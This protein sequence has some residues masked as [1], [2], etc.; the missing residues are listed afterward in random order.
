MTSTVADDLSD[1]RPY[2]FLLSSPNHA[3]IHRRQSGE[4]GL[5]SPTTGE[6]RDHLLS[7][8]SMLTSALELARQAVHLDYTDD[9]PAAVEA[10]AR[11]V[12]LLSLVIERGK[13]GEDTGTRRRSPEAQEKEVRRLQSIVCVERLLRLSVL[14]I[15]EA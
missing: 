1:P 11:S 2:P 8:R 10:Y 7:S 5:L 6:R 14:K 15:L 4:D 12:A 3:E 9:N 13:R